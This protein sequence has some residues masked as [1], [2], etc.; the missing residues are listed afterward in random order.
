MS[1]KPKNRHKR[2]ISHKF[3]LLKKISKHFCSIKHSQCT[4]TYRW[5]DAHSF[6][7][8]TYAY[9]VTPNTDMKVYSYSR[10]TRSNNEQ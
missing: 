4:D 9:T 5:Y 6:S 7:I 3:N 2:V 8:I 1:K 10:L